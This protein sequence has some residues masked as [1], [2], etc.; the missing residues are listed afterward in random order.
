MYD[1][2][3]WQE[4]AGGESACYVHGEFGDRGVNLEMKS[5]AL[6]VVRWLSP[7]YVAMW[8]RRARRYHLPHVAAHGSE[9]HTVT[10]LGK[11]F[12]IVYA[13]IYENVGLPVTLPIL[14]LMHCHQSEVDIVC[15]HD[16][17]ATPPPSNAMLAQPA[18]QCGPAE[19]SA[20]AG[21]MAICRL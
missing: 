14:F 3:N 7:L 10:G 8:E 17:L 20:F 4:E 15:R 18:A 6:R 13:V 5:R 19:M 1:S 21:S 11:A 12:R 16:N 9:H 2:R